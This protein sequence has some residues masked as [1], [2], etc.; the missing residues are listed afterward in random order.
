[1][2]PCGASPCLREL[3]RLP[4]QTVVQV[5]LPLGQTFC[6][7]ALTITILLAAPAPSW[8]ESD[9]DAAIKYDFDDPP[10]TKHRLIRDLTY[11]SQTTLGFEYEQDYDLDRGEDDDLATLEPEL[12]VALSYDPAPWFRAFANLDLKRQFPIEEPDGRASQKT[13]LRVKEAYV[14]FREVLQGVS[15]TVG[16]QEFKDEREWLFDEDLDA[17][18]LFY[19]NSNFGLEVSVSREE[20]LDKD[21]L[22]EESVDHINNYFLVG[23]YALGE[24][25]ELTPFF[26]VRDDRTSSDEDLVFLGM[27][28]TGEL[29][30]DIDYWAQF[31]HVRGSEDGADIRGYG[32]DV[33]AT[34][35][36]DVDFEPS[37]TLGAAFGSGDSDPDN[38]DRNFRQTGLQDNNDR[39]NGVTSFKYYGEV[40]DPE[41]SNLFILTAGVGVRPTKRSSID[42]VY[43]H[44]R[45][46]QASDDLRD[47]SIDEDPDGRERSLGNGLDLIVGYREI[48]DVSAEAVFGLFDPGAAFSSDADTA[49]FIGFEVEFSF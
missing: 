20:L 45:Q 19:R 44:Y 10:D 3:R 32:F 29:T 6:F 47:V 16:R 17:A 12:E 37:L 48:E 21:I 24:D 5:L 11:G 2:K 38:K 39:F 49:Y 18:R 31:A 43:H 15:A 34:Y 40:L 42:L 14:T 1:M 8:S 28:S 23:R 27:S 41:L 33:G 35:T 9:N 30:S 25:S 36:L 7:S 4:L 13:R 46:H 22:N 26:L